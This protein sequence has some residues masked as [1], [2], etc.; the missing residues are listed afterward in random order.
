MSGRGIISGIRGGWRAKALP[1]ALAVAATLIVALLFAAV[2]DDASPARAAGKHKDPTRD[3]LAVSNNWDGTVDLVDAHTFKRLKRLNI[4]PDREQRMAEIQTNPDRLAFFIA[5]RNQIG[6]GH[7]QLAD[8]AFTSPDGRFIYVSRP[9]FADV[10]AINMRTGR[11][12]WRV[13]V[14]GYRSDHMAIS[15]NGSR[16]LVSASTA[17]KVHV[18]DTRQGQIVAS[19][20][21]GDSPHEN[22]FS[23]D[24]KLIFHASIGRVYTPTDSP[25]ENATKGE[26]IFEIV[27]ARTYKVKR[28]IDMSVKLDQAGYPDMSGAVRPMTLSPNERFIYFQVSF[29]HGFV[30]FDRRKNRVRRVAMLPLSQEAQE[31]SRQEYILDSAH[32]GIAMN[33][34]GTRLCVAGTMSNYAAIVSRKTFAYKIIKV[35]DRPYWS[36]PSENGRYCFVS[37]AGADRVSV[38]SYRK[39]KQVASIRVG[40]HPQRMRTGDLR[41]AFLRG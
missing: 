2:D 4:V 11:I 15:R 32:H 9:S 13:P 16:L 40:D 8:D 10:V 28:R 3:I 35:G 14:E 38:I 23:K 30:E 33:P 25:E 17:N 39:R 24:G 5:I 22:N 21:S 7:D 31:M 37:V 36:T 12:R 26:E 34:R 19:F 29:F 1:A 18:I 41:R 27:D 6:E 20:P